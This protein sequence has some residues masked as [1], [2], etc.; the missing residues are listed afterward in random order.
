MRIRTRLQ[1]AAANVNM[2]PTRSSPRKRVLRCNATVIIQPNT[3]STRSL[4]WQ[5]K[6][7]LR[8]VPRLCERPPK[9][10]RRPGARLRSGRS[11][12][13][14]RRRIQ[15]SRMN[16]RQSVRLALPRRSPA[17][18]SSIPVFFLIQ[19]S[20][21]SAES[22]KAASAVTLQ[23]R[24]SHRHAGSVKPLLADREMSGPM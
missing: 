17:R 21:S 7:F 24:T 6:H 23:S 22:V 4:R 8:V 20:R 12:L 15:H 14:R 2:Q 16:R 3:S 1:A 5:A 9:P 18:N 19:P 13:Q 10:W 11:A